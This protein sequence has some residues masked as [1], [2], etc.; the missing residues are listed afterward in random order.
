MGNPSVAHVISFFI[1]HFYVALLAP[2]NSDECIFMQFRMYKY[3]FISLEASTEKI[4]ATFGKIPFAFF[5]K[6]A[7][8]SRNRNPWN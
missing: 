1:S 4:E 7:P 6:E 8:F 2:D 5:K 3:A